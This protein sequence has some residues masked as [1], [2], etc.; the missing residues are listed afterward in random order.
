MTVE[1]NID[2]VTAYNSPCPLPELRYYMAGNIKLQ[3]SA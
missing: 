2:S 1:R 3:N